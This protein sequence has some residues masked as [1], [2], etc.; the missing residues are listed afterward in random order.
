MDT[1]KKVVLH[2]VYELT[3]LL[4]ET[5]TEAEVSQVKTDVEGLLKKYKATIL[6]DED[7]GKQRLAYI[8]TH[9]AH[10]NTEG[11]Y[12]H[13]VFKMDALQAPVFEHD[14][15]LQNKIMRHLLLKAEEEETP[16]VEEKKT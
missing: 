14:I 7:W 15:F 2:R 3:Y 1:P 9:N 8:I 4:P 5:L 6:K 13:V 11:Y 10:K 16:V 12:K